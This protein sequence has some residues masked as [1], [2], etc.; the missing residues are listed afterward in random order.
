M[1]I[2][3]DA[4]VASIAIDSG[5]ATGVV[6]ASGETISGRTVIANASAQATFLKLVAPG[7][8]P[9]DFVS[10]VR[11]IRDASTSFKVHFGLR[12]LPVFRH[13]D[14]AAQGFAYPD[15]FKV[16]PSVDYIE[17][18]YDDSKYGRFSRRPVMTVMTP[19]VADSTLAPPGMH[20]MSIFAQHAPYALRGR[21]W[22]DDKARDDL[23]RTVLETLDEFSPDLRECIVHHQV[24]TPLDYERI[25]ALPHG[26]THHAELSADQVFFRRPVR[27]YGGYNTPV[28]G[29]FLCGA[30]V[31]PG[32][33]VTGVPGHNA[34]QVVLKTLGRG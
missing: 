10:E 9:D 5:R 22:D 21:S 14:P 27:K 19:S 11:R 30:S 33:G 28:A 17:R 12:R 4:E 8:L 24:L 16:G 20:V 15:V 1:E 25:F 7:A 31:H 23:Y 13:F 34:A 29:L 3:T 6:L 18:A 2:S 32:G 26:H